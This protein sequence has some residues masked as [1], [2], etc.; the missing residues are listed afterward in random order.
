VSFTLYNYWRS[1]ASWRVRIGLHWK[2]I[3]FTYHAV[4]LLK[5]GGEQWQ[6]AHLGRNP[7]GMV[8]VLEW[9]ENG[10]TRRLAQ[11][12]AILE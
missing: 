5:D 11:S 7:Q 9:E 8:P 12:L 1:S 10:Q 3:P 2:G 4:N 6:P